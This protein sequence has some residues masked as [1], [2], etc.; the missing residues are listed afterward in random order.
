MAKLIAF[1]QLCIADDYVLQDIPADVEKLRRIGYGNERPT[2]VLLPTGQYSVT[3][4][5]RRIAALQ[6]LRDN[7]RPAFDRALPSG[8]V[9][10]IV[11]AGLSIIE[12]EK[13]GL[14]SVK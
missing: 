1:D 9:S 3:W 13:L 7:D 8:K 5:Y 14:R 6:W 2:V 11:L 10:C 12:E 4:G